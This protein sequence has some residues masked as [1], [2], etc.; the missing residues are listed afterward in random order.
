MWYCLQK[1]VK[2]NKNGDF[3]EM[4]TGFV[5]VGAETPVQR[6]DPSLK[7]LAVDSDEEEV[8]RQLETVQMLEEDVEG[9]QIASCIN[10]LK[11]HKFGTAGVDVNSVPATNVDFMDVTGEV[12]AEVELGKEQEILLASVATLQDENEK[13]KFELK[14]SS[15]SLD[16]RT[17]P[18][19]DNEIMV[20]HAE[21][22]VPERQ[23]QS[24]KDP[25]ER[26]KLV[27][28]IAEISQKGQ[29]KRK[30]ADGNPQ[31]PKKK[32]FLTVVS[33]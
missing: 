22:K 11:V 2:N 10:T 3:S 5:E 26:A 20:E 13:E 8:K 19:N 4:T 23:T 17:K 28:G 31:I 12:G 30:Q 15:A 9:E 14:T 27:S 6:P 33:F 25:D 16:E 32:P 7:T 18:K 24:H 29:Q 1:D 21:K